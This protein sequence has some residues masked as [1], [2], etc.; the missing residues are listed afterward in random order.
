MSAHCCLLKSL[1]LL[2]R[3]GKRGAV[4]FDDD[5]SKGCLVGLRKIFLVVE[6]LYIK[7]TEKEFIMQAF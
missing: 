3:L 5:I 4:S 6:D 7:G 1:T 2:Q